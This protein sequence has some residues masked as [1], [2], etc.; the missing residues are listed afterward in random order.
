MGG[1]DSQTIV[2]VHDYAR[3]DFAIIHW[4]QCLE[5][6]FDSTID[7]FLKIRGSR[8]AIEFGFSGHLVTRAQFSRISII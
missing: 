2:F 1:K 8:S 3:S 6:H 7:L 5:Q 4:R